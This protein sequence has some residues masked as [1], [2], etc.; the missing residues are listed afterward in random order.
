[1]GTGSCNTVTETLTLRG[2][3]KTFDARSPLHVLEDIDLSIREGEFVSFIGPSGCGKSTLLAILAGLLE[4]TTGTVR[5]ADHPDKPLLGKVAY[6]P[7]KDLLLPW[8]SLL[9]NTIIGME[10]RGWARSTSRKR[11]LGLFPAFGLAGFEDYYPAHLSGGMRQRAAFLRT[12]L[13]DRSILL[14]DEPFGAL[15]ALTRATLQ[16]WLLNLWDSLETIIVLVTHDVEEALLLSDRICVMT[17]RPGRIKEIITVPWGRPRTFSIVT[18]PE[19]TALRRTL[20]NSLYADQPFTS[21]ED[22]Q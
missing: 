14:L 2:V 13:T 4:P 9:D 12:L 1:M 22:S 20:L 5:F 10:C 15:D 6:M 17:E 19:F 3:S 7:Q 21:S 18:A 11:A 8:R 16:T